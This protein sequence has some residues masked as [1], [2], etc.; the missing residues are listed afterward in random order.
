MMKKNNL[1]FILFLFISFFS[2]SRSIRDDVKEIKVSVST[3]ET[4][5]TL[6]YKVMAGPRKSFR[7]DYR[8][9]VIDNIVYLQAKRE[10]SEKKHRVILRTTK[11]QKVE[12][13]FILVVSFSKSGDKEVNVVKASSQPSRNRYSAPLIEAHELVRHA[14]QRLYSPEYAVEKPNLLSKL[15]VDKNLVLDSIYRGSSLKIR[16]IV[17]FVHKNT[18]VHA[19]EVVNKHNYVQELDVSALYGRVD[20]IGASFQHRFV[21]TNNSSISTLYIVS[22]DLLHNTIAI[23]TGG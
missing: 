20:A 19:L 5:I 8:I 14:A 18:Y 2:E 13:T 3:E 17:T 22:A 12:K 23:T 6:P 11:G 15:S 1:L 21:G 16:P 4:K 10:L 7:K 9:E